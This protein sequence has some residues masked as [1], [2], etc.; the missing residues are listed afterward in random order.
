MIFQDP[1]SSMNPI[2]N[3]LKI[4]SEPLVINKIVQKE[5]WDYI[6]LITNINRYFKN[7]FNRENV[8]NFLNFQKNY[9]SSILE[10]Y[11]DSINELNEYKNLEIKNLL[12]ASELIDKLLNNLISKLQKN[13][14]QSYGLV[15][16][17]KDLINSTIDKFN[18]NDLHQIDIDLH[19][20]TKNLINIKK[21]KNNS[22]KLL[23][24]KKELKELKK[25]IKNS[26]KNF[27]NLYFVDLSEYKKV[28]LY[29]ILSNIKTFNQSKYQSKNNIQYY[30]FYIQELLQKLIYQT[31]HFLLKEF[32]YLSISEIEEL[33]INVE[34]YILDKF[35]S[36]ISELL[37][38]EKE[39]NEADLQ[40]RIEIL[41]NISKYKKTVEN[42][43]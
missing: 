31:T 24:L 21:L 5:A 30:Y 7:N 3:V 11:Q 14:E 13:V 33:S 17:Q 32:K 19:E 2:K 15:S 10:I 6:K 38:Y 23:D 39:F 42:I 8:Y 27:R 29:K 28:I 1:M 37:N 40:K 34:K 35:N 22:E 12:E 36:P 41:D 4:V 16:Q 20:T 26:N 25:E 43:K 9:Y 18:A